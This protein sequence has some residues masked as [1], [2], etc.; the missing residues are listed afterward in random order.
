[1]G[2]RGL[3]GFYKNG[4]TKA[5]YNQFDTYPTGLGK[6]M[7]NFVKKHWK[8]MLTHFDKI[9]I[10][11]E[12]SKPTKKQLKRALQ[13]CK[14][15]LNVSMQSINDWYCVLHDAQ[16][17]P[18]IYAKGL[19]LLL[20]ATDFIKDSL[21][22]EWAYIMNLDNMTLEIYKG[23]NK[24]KQSVKKNRYMANA[25]KDEQGYYPCKLIT[26]YPFEIIATL[27]QS[28]INDICIKLRHQE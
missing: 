24:R 28:Y 14:P 21:F 1:M 18:E 17:N 6:I 15:D 22:C 16:N 20:D 8:K 10:V 23:F 9:E 11:K 2:T 7:F 3:Y 25:I 12:D 13:Y 4:V 5:V 27:K 19:D 26:I